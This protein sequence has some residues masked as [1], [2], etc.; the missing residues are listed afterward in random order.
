MPL[1]FDLFSADR[2]GPLLRADAELRYKLNGFNGTLRV[3]VADRGLDL[4]V[5]DGAVAD[6][7]PAAEE[8]AR[9]ALTIPADVI[10]DAVARPPVPGTESLSLA[11]SRGAVIAG[12]LLTDL[13]PYAGAAGRVYQLLRK[14]AGVE[15]VPLPAGGEALFADTDTAVGRYVHVTV[16]GVRY[17]VFYE[18]AGTGDEVLLLQHTAGCD[19]RQWRHQLADP[20]FQSRY[21][22][23]AYDLPYHGRSLPPVGVRWWE[24]AYLP[25]PEWFWDFVVAFADALG[26]DHPHFM[27]CSV[28]GQLALDLAA[29]R[30]DRFGA[31]FA[32]NGTLDNP[33]AG[34]PAVAGF[35]DLC[36]DNRVSTELYGTGNFSATSPLGPEPYR[37][38]IYWIYRSNFPGAYAGDNDY[39]LTGHDLTQGS[40]QFDVERHPVYV[41]GGEY[42]PVAND[43]DHG[44]P[45]VAARFPGIQ[46]E[47]LQGLSHFA[48]TDDP[49][50]FRDAI[51]PLLERGIG[52]YRAAAAVIG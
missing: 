46:S 35:N 6:V 27:G 23:I 50:G 45:A 13:A 49:L 44:G 16:Q 37:R 24:Q 12:D 38:E 25:E 20:E 42:D 52:A 40:P 8:P 34:D 11:A 39:F 3:T 30:G 21:R 1:D 33:V 41:I 14:A 2:L 51:L 17:R 19:G 22:L 4:V 5:A 48:P 43:P 15:E 18:E 28:G 29:Y 9:L 7:R 32:L 36:R 26:L 47:T 10:E 31:F